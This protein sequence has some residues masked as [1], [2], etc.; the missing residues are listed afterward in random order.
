MKTVKKVIQS[1]FVMGSL[2]TCSMA[3]AGDTSA[4]EQ[5]RVETPKQIATSEYNLN[6]E[7]LRLQLT[8]ELQ[9]QVQINI[10][11]QVQTL[12]TELAVSVKNVA[13]R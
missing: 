7:A 5:P 1:F 4:G 3:M 2:F 11:H 9:Q 8:E 13:T 6:L 12:F 10:Q